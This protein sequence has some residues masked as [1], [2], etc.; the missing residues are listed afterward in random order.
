MFSSSV[1]ELATSATLNE[2]NNHKVEHEMH[3]CNEVSASTV[4]E[5][6]MTKDKVKF[7]L[8]PVDLN[9]QRFHLNTIDFIAL[10]LG[11]NKFFS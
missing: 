9:S 1:H 8:I 11:C 5:L 6:T 2:L 7:Q 10:L 4:G 3:Q